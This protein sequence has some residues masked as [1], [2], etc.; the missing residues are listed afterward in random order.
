MP[1]SV[2][3][4]PVFKALL[5]FSQEDNFEESMLSLVAQEHQLTSQAHLFFFFPL[6]TLR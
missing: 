3:Q 5:L 4:R 6:S 1:S 2:Y